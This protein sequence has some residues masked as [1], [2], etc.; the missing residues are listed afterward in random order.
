MTIPFP[1]LAMRTPRI[2]RRA[3]SRRTNPFGA[4]GRGWIHTGPLQLPERFK[5]GLAPGR[6]HLPRGD[7]PRDV[8]PGMRHKCHDI[9]HFLI[10]QHGWRHGT[11]ER[12]PIHPNLTRQSLTQ[13]A[14]GSFP[15]IGYKIGTGQGRKSPGDPLSI[16]LMTNETTSNI[17]NLPPLST[18][19][20]VGTSG[21]RL[22]R[23]QTLRSGRERG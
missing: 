12:L 10:V 6:R 2:G 4:F 5:P 19:C 14:K 17:E 15:L 23:P 21:F 7:I 20:K 9:G 13:G 11:S 22:F 3:T 1:S 18:G 8:P 16:Q